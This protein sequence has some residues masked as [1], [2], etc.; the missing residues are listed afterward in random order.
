MQQSHSLEAYSQSHR[1][2]IPSILYNQKVHYRVHNSP[3]TAHILSQMNLVHTFPPYFPK[4]YSNI[5]SCFPTK[6]SHAFLIFPMCGTCTANLI[7]LDMMSVIIHGE[8]PCRHLLIL[9]VFTKYLYHLPMLQSSPSVL[10]YINMCSFPQSWDKGNATWYATDSGN[11]LNMRTKR[12]QRSE[13][14]T[15]ARIQ[16]DVFW[17]VT[18]CSDARGYPR[19]EGLCYLH[20]Q[21][22]VT[23]EAA[24]TSETSVSY[25]NTTR[26]HDP[27]GFAFNDF[28]IHYT[29]K[30]E[31]SDTI[32]HN[33]TP[34]SSCD[35]LY[36]WNTT[37]VIQIQFHCSRNVNPFL[38]LTTT[39][40]TCTRAY[41]KVSGLA[42]WREN[43]KWYSS[44][45]LGAVVSLFYESV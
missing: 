33:K 11:N 35:S 19:F 25:R 26:H 10:I 21:G 20:L 17:I 42:A 5:T 30:W 37:T 9:T 22:E 3:P 43:W 38:R 13:V 29:Y 14:F 24:R 39:P 16:I 40:W 8:A 36:R 18:P 12:K 6:I 41:P 32:R 31:D 1:Q 44:L 4:I 27:E 34:A 28:R 7:L 15:A 23:M 2:E 45:P